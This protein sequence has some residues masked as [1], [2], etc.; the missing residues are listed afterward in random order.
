[1]T[2]FQVALT[3]CDLT[4]EKVSECNIRFKVVHGSYGTGKCMVATRPSATGKYDTS[5]PVYVGDIFTVDKLVSQKE[6]YI[7][8]MADGTQADRWVLLDPECFVQID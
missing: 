2:N 6:Y 1:M 8:H 7:G 5:K 4:E 3:V